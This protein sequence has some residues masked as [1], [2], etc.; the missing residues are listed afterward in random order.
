MSIPSIAE[1]KKQKVPAEQLAAAIESIKNR[2]KSSKNN[3]QK[4]PPE[5]IISHAIIIIQ[6]IDYQV[7]DV[8][9]NPD[10]TKYT[11]LFIIENTDTAFSFVGNAFN[12]IPNDASAIGFGLWAGPT[13]EGAASLIFDTTTDPTQPIAGIVDSSG[14]LHGWVAFTAYDPNTPL[15]NVSGYLS[16]IQNN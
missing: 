1:L 4:N 2:I 11:L 14:T 8:N 15:E 16:Q 7:W 12:K 9:A 6:N 10:L 13:F 3:N 5:I